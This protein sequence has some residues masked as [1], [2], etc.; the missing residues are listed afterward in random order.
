MFIR[1]SERCGRGGGEE[2]GMYGRLLHSFIVFK[3]FLSLIYLSVMRRV[4]L[5]RE[6]RQSL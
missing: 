5:V 4:L 3:V 1:K 6:E 2:G